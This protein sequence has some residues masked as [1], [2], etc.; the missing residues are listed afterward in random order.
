MGNLY[1]EAEIKLRA[2]LDKLKDTIVNSVGENVAA[3]ASIS[4]AIDRLTESVNNLNETLKTIHPEINN[5][6]SEG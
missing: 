5:N 1:N 3:T 6:E 4:K 2:S